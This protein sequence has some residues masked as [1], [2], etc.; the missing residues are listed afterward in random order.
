[1]KPAAAFRER[2]LCIACGSKDLEVLDE[3]SYGDGPFRKEIESSPW[4]ESPMPHLETARWTFVRCKACQQ[5]FHRKILTPEWD[6]IRHSRWMTLDAIR[7]F[8]RQHG[9]ERVAFA[10]ALGWVEH[11]LRLDR[12][13]R[14]LRGTKPLR[15]LDF[16]CGFGGF[17]DM[18]SRFGFDAVGVDRSHAR[19]AGASVVMIYSSLEELARSKAGAQKFHAITLFEVLEHLDDPMSILRELGKF[20]GDGGFLV[21]ETPDC[22]GLRRLV[23]GQTW[24]LADGL[25]HINGFTPA[26]LSAMAARAGFR[27]IRRPT[28]QASASPFGVLKREARRC[29]GPI[30]RKTTQQY[31]VRSR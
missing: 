21:L 3:G 23:P 15:V 8:E 25:D 16:G 4:G 2:A 7:E 11:V 18:C 27:Q 6:E 10:Q 5:M 12:L 17:V 30:L 29:L 31:F 22:T 19:Q 28:V 26:T 20:V 13:T 14:E 24:H 1:M 9:S